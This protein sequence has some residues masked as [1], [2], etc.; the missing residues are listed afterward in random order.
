M[1]PSIRKGW[2]VLCSQPSPVIF[3]LH[4]RLS[5]RTYSQGGCAR[6]GQIVLIPAR[7]DGNHFKVLGKSKEEGVDLV[8]ICFNCRVVK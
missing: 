5:M 6:E 3:L 4:P 2:S 8:L 7:A 1:L